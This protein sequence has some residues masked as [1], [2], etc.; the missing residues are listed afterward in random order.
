MMAPRDDCQMLVFA[1]PMEERLARGLESRMKAFLKAGRST[2]PLDDR[3]FSALHGSGQIADYLL[4]NRRFIAEMKAVNG[5]PSD[6]ITRLVNDE[7]R[8]EPRMFVMGSV[9]IQRILSDRE[10][11]EDLNRMMVSI[12]G[13]PI[14]KL[15][16]QA[17]P[18]IADTRSKLRLPEAAGL[19]IILIDS[20]QK[21]EA[22]VAA[23]AVRA[24][25]EAEEPLLDQIDFVWVSIEAH[26]VRL[27]DGRL[28]YP[29]IG[30]WRGGRRP[31]TD[32][33]MMGQM[34]DAWAAFN[35]VELEH[36][37]HTRG[38]ET[39]DPVGD[40]WPLALNLA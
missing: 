39:L 28:G 26:T 1:R 9:G 30:I 32:Q 31:E 21:V 18:Q 12:G 38:W 11:G 23:Y 27:P 8:K 10:N 14:R 19:A 3:K 4:W 2:E 16:Q 13:R 33:A 22:G 35:G 15:L 36:L 5:Y 34:F 24:A 17:D 20:P 25:L 6:R 29:E 7:L 37:D 40:G